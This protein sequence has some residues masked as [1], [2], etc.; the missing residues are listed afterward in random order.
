MNNLDIESLL[1]KYKNYIRKVIIN[2]SNGMLKNEDI[3]DVESEVYEKIWQNREKLL[4]VKSVK[5]YI[6]A[7]T[8]NV[9]KDKIKE[10]IK[11]E[12]EV[13]ITDEICSVEDNVENI[14]E[15]KEAKALIEKELSKL[16]EDEQDIFI[17]F[18][19][20]DE[21]TKTIAREKKMSDSNVRV[22]LHRI[23]NKLQKEIEG[24]GYYT[25]R[26][27]SVIIWIVIATIG[28]AFAKELI[29]YLF[30]DS[31][32]GIKKAVENGYVQEVD[33]AYSKSNN[34]ELKVDNVLMD[35]FNLNIIFTVKF[36]KKE[37]LDDVTKCILPNIFITDENNNFIVAKFESKDN[38][39]LY[40]SIKDKISE[41]NYD[42][43]D[44]GGD[45]IRIVDEY[46]NTLKISYRVHS[47][48]FP[49]SKKLNIKMDK[50]Q[51]VNNKSNIEDYS[52]EWNTSIN[53][54]EQFY[55]R[56][57]ILYD[58]E[59]CNDDSVNFEYAKVTNSGCEVK[60][61]ISWNYLFNNID[62]EKEEKLSE[63]L[64]DEE[65]IE[66]IANSFYVYVENQ[67]S[68]RYVYIDELSGILEIRIK[69]NGK[70]EF[71]LNFDITK[72]DLTDKL[73]LHLLKSKDIFKSNDEIIL[74]L[75]QK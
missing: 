11:N 49:R 23:R 26:I 18:Y 14:Y 63:F 72:Y 25:K 59:S 64:L 67:A 1:E 5:N 61:N 2:N 15:N 66:N 31:S 57:A 70:M 4:H 6:V 54:D 52:G 51:L 40:E 39:K 44:D 24:K 55:N 34:V 29:T 9:T 27:I 8:K 10:V 65:N 74:E 7:I 75:T 48:N 41:I 42:G 43:I 28:I 60:F 30:S 32:Y 45:S 71:D 22:K 38:S 13:E 47:S 56:E 12:T 20:K 36:D 35:D 19:I 17:R 50:M 37:N 21:S 53:L 33:S 16:S 73:Y 62:N 68:E 69:E 46:D 3:E 58:M